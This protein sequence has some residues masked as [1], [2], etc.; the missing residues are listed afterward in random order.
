LTLA[1][2]IP[3]CAAGTAKEA[4]GSEL[5]ANVPHWIAAEKLPR[6]ARPGARIFATSGCTAC[7]VY[8]G[9]GA[10]NLGAP[11]L[12][13][14]G[15]RGRG[16]DWQVRHLENPATV[17]PGSPMPKFASLGQVRLHELAVFLE[18]SKGER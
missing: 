6:A 4:V 5:I 15:L 1:S 12:T 3:G 16:I 7:H 14:E 8:L 9:A 11:N 2:L 10:Q 17:V 13:S 18:D